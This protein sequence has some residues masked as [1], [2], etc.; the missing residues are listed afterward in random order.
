MLTYAFLHDNATSMPTAAG[1]AWT[2][3]MELPREARFVEFA[4]IGGLVCLLLTRRISTESAGLAAGIL[5]FSSLATLSY[6]QHPRVGLTDFIRLVYM[7]VLPIVIFVIAREYRWKRA[8][9]STLVDFILLWILV[10][11]AVSW[12]QYSYF[13]YEPGDDITGL[14][15]DAHANAALLMIATFVL[16]AQGLFLHRPHRILVAIGAAVTA[17]LP[18]ALKTLFMFPLLLTVFVMYY[19]GASLRSL[20]RINKRTLIAALVVAIMTTMIFREFARI[21]F[22]S[23]ARLPDFVQRVADNPASLGLLAGYRDAI[24]LLLKEPGTFLFGLGPFSHSNPISMG[25]TLEGGALSV[26]ARPDLVARSGE[27][28]EDTRVTLMTALAAELGFPALIALAVLYAMIV[29]RLHRCTRS[30]EPVV[31]AYAAALVP[32]L[33]LVLG[34][35]VLGLFG[36]ISSLS[37]TWPLMLVGGATARLH[38]RAAALDPRPIPAQAP[39]SSAPGAP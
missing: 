15:Q 14:N 39:V 29:R 9:L 27:S 19:A 34:S 25:Q 7:F 22:R 31:R 38:S 32:S 5:V 30:R 6:L 28:G 23:S 10:S 13:G 21:D 17:V 26:A 12:A 36:S 18:S 4:G 33:L 11:A 35:G 37:L 1:Y 2:R 8:N 16:L 3:L 20:Q 24:A